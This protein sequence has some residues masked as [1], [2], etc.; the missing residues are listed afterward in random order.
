MP[1]NSHKISSKCDFNKKMTKRKRF[2]IKV[3]R[4]F[5]FNSKFQ[6]MSVITKNNVD[7]SFR[8]YIKGAPEKIVQQC[9]KESIPKT[10]HETLLQ[11]TKN[12]LRVLACATKLL[13]NVVESELQDED[14]RT[15][16]ESNLT[17][18]GFIIFRNK[19]KRDTKNVIE[20]LNSSECNIFIATGD[21]PF[22][23]ISVAKE[24]ELF[25]NSNILLCKI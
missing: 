8:F 1:R 4:R 9:K 3:L 16:Y 11:H 5:D 24:C 13:T 23:T 14:N 19:L 15:K 22:T 25:K 2:F 10:Y 6:S 7:D 12:G 17:F 21:N 20:N 18:L